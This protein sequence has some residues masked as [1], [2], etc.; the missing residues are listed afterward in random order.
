MLLANLQHTLDVQEKSHLPAL[1]EEK[2]VGLVEE[3]GVYSLF[4]SLLAGMVQ[5]RLEA[6]LSSEF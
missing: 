6:N 1:E 5:S 4:A 2:G 3:V